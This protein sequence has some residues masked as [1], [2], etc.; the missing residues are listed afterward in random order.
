[1]LS[2]TQELPRPWGLESSVRVGGWAKAKAK[3]GSGR[4]GGCGSLSASEA[5][6]GACSPERSTAQ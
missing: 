6:H 2:Q 5:S 4:S 3:A 1:M